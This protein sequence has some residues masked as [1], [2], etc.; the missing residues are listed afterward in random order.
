M[1]TNLLLSNIKT[2]HNNQEV[3][4]D[5]LT[6]FTSKIKYLSYKLKYPEAETDLIIY[7]Y[8]LLKVIDEQKF[9]TDKD[10]LMYIYKC[11]NNKSISLFHKIAKDKESMTFTSEAETLD[12]ID[13]NE[14]DDEYSDIVFN[15]L[16]SSLN[17]KQ[18]ELMF[19]KF[20]LQ[21]SDIEIAK[22]FKIT[23]QAVNKSLRKALE[24]LRQELLN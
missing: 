11:L 16:I 7:L 12:V 19:Y 22:L 15:D 20:Y 2:F 3:F 5:I 24:T 6:H 13:C 8:E 1:P 18:K 23:R 4:G 21:L 10:I 14:K 9:N 17:P